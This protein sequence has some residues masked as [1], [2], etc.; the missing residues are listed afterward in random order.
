M[1]IRMRYGCYD[2]FYSWLL[3]TT[4]PFSKNCY[5]LAFFEKT[6]KKYQ[7]EVVAPYQ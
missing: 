2:K 1:K 3:M 5:F 6:K 4:L 7:K